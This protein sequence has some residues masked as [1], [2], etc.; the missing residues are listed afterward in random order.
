MDSKNLDSSTSPNFEKS[1]KNRNN[2]VRC[3]RYGRANPVS[4]NES[5]VRKNL[6][7]GEAMPTWNDKYIVTIICYFDPYS[8]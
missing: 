8:K 7:I 4:N 1:Y 2:S 6:V 3:F 5:T